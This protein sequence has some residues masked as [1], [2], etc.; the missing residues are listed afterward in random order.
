MRQNYV[1]VCVYRQ[2][3]SPQRLIMPQSWSLLGV[4]LGEI[5]LDNDLRK[6]I[7]GM[8]TKIKEITNKLQN[9]SLKNHKQFNEI[10]L[11]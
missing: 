7:I 6:E 5:L 2:N 4:K 9:E 3:K 1:C 11:I 10:K 8:F